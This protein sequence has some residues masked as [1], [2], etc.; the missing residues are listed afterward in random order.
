M[1]HQP[2]MSDYLYPTIEE[3]MTGLGTMSQ[4]VIADFGEEGLEAGWYDIVHACADHC[5]PEVAEELVRR[6]L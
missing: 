4:D 5:P 3:A 1:P 6:N 2:I